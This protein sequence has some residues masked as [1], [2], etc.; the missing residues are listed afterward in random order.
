MGG[1]QNHVKGQSR[2]KEGVSPKEELIRDLDWERDNFWCP[3]RASGKNFTFEDSDKW[4]GPSSAHLVEP[5][6]DS[7]TVTQTE[8]SCHI[9]Y[10]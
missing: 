8:L 4:F 7:D 1:L 3:S 6:L 5:E 9:T 2:S 10:M